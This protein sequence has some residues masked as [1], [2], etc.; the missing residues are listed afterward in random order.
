MIALLRQLFQGHTVSRAES[1]AGLTDAAQ[2]GWVVLESVLKPIIL[3]LKADE[4]ACGFPVAGDDDLAS[5]RQA[6]I[7]GQIVLHFREGDFT[8]RR[9][10]RAT[11][12]PLS[13][14]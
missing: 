14:R 2:K 3:V 4:N 10:P 7:A 5:R 9:T 8:P 13:W 6:E 12:Q 11:L 1:S